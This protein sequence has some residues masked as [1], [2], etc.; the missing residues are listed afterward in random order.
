MGGARGNN[1]IPREGDFSLCV[2]CGHVLAFRADQT[3][4]KIT[5]KEAKE[6]QRWWKEYKRERLREFNKAKRK[7]MS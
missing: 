5:D 2:K 4:R 3:V 1:P 6:F 7:K